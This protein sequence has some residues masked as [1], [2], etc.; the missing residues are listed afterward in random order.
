MFWF[1]HVTL[2]R[3]VTGDMKSRESGGDDGLSR[4]GLLGARSVVV[5]GIV[6][7]LLCPPEEDGCNSESER[8]DSEYGDARVVLS[9]QP[10]VYVLSL[11]LIHNDNERTEHC[12]TNLP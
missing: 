3:S 8:R 2:T 6:L 4:T 1:G 10:V 9:E 11:T 12:Q 5:P 7:R